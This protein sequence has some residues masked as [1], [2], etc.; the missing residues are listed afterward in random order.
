MLHLDF[1]AMLELYTIFE[2]LLD[3]ILLVILC[4]L[5]R[6]PERIIATYTSLRKHS[7]RKPAH[8]SLF[9]SLDLLCIEYSCMNLCSICIAF[10]RSTLLIAKL[11]M[12]YFYL[13]MPL[14]SPALSSTRHTIDLHATCAFLLISTQ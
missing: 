1:C 10:F 13:Q 6:K 8:V 12:S 2:Y 9:S 7:L 4:F 5:C 11:G 14:M 3:F